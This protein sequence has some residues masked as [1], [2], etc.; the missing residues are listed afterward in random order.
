MSQMSGDELSG[1]GRIDGQL[2]R[3]LWG[4]NGLAVGG[5][6]SKQGDQEK[7]QETEESSHDIKSNRQRTGVRPGFV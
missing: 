3:A 1:N 4:I 6:T 2:D 7:G 5:R